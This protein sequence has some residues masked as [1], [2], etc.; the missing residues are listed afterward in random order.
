MWL[1]DLETQSLSKVT[2]TSTS[3]VNPV[4]SPV[5]GTLAFGSNRGGT[6]G[7][8]RRTPGAAGEDRLLGQNKLPMLP[9]DWSKDGRYLAYVSGGDVWAMPVAGGEPLHVTDSPVFQETRAT[10]SPDGR[11]IAYQSTE[12]GGVTQSNEGDIFIQSFP[13]RSIK[14][15]VTAA[16]GF[17][18]KWSGDG[19]ELFYIATD[20]TLM[21]ATIR[22]TATSLDIGAPK[23]LFQPGLGN[24]FVAFYTVLGDGRFLVGARESPRQ[25]RVVLNWQEE[26]KRLATGATP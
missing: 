15:Q 21:A 23:P 16:G 2:V 13:E 17:V 6:N 10:F 24:P 8:Y 12:A 9:T 11:W 25:I 1:L 26:L 22:A 19:K 18:P 7:L 14:R 5:D 4:W 20:G 3:D